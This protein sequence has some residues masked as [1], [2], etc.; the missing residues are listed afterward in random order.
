MKKNAYERIDPQAHPEDA[1]Q[2]SEAKTRTEIQKALAE[3]F[4]KAWMVE[5]TFNRDGKDAIPDYMAEVQ[6]KVEVRWKLMAEE[7]PK[8]WGDALE[9]ELKSQLAQAN[10]AP[11]KAIAE[12]AAQGEAT[13]LLERLEAEAQ[14]QAGN[15]QQLMLQLVTSIKL[16]TDE[17][18]WFAGAV[19]IYE[20]G[21]FLETAAL[22]VI[23]RARPLFAR[24]L[25][26]REEYR[27]LQGAQDVKGMNPADVRLIGGYYFLIR[28]WQNAVRYL[29]VTAEQEKNNWGKVE[30]IPVDPRQKIV[31]RSA[32]ADELAV[33]YML[34]KAYLELHK[35]SGDRDQLVKAALHL[36]RCV[37]FNEIRDT[38]ELSKGADWKLSFQK[39]LEQY[40]VAG[41]QAMAE[42]YVLLH[43]QKDLKVDW[44]KYVSQ[45]TSTLEPKKENGE[46]VLQPVPKDGPGYL[47][48]A[49]QARLKIWAS[50]TELSA[51]QY[52]SEY[53]TNLVAWIEL[54]IEWK[55]TYGADKAPEG[56]DP[57]QVS[58]L[59][60]EAATIAKR[61]AEFKAAY[62]TDDT[63]KH[64]ETMKKLAEAI[65]KK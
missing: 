27:V 7:Y 54:M 32:N 26:Y 33:R 14:K 28:D 51:Y 4:W 20:F 49:A 53:R 11:I 36:R 39:E 35:Q 63:K 64:V 41:A 12:K 2:L 34:G 62:M 22:D 18:Q 43:K 44:P 42:T 6:T 38:V 52:R 50:F 37:C 19:F 47:W 5:K 40:Y 30:E 60:S 23:D 3:H 9:A 56:V 25:K 65:E 8:R 1:K 58:K 31:G 45:Q 10:F 16:N 48:F 59:M 15:N 29:E 21:G 61:E 46:V 24:I 55:G 13:T 57:K 17:L